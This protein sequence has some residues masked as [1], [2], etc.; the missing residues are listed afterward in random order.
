MSVLLFP[1]TGILS[2]IMEGTTTAP[3]AIL[4]SLEGQVELNSFSVK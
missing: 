1:W 2:G 3:A 4:V